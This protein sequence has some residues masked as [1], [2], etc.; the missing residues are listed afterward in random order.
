[1]S[2]AGG[3]ADFRLPPAAAVPYSF[4]MWTRRRIPPFPGLAQ[5]PGEEDWL[6]LC[7]G[8]AVGSVHAQVTSPMGSRWHWRAGPG[9]GG[10]AASLQEALEAVRAAVLA[11]QGAQGA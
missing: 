7:A 2:D 6:V 11:A 3:G 1:M 8:R 4:L 5:R 10:P 9:Q